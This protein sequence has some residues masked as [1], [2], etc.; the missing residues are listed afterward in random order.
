MAARSRLISDLADQVRRNATGETPAWAAKR[1]AAVPAELIAD[2]QI[3]RAAT[4]V[5]PGDL[6]PTGPSQIGQFFAALQVRYRQPN[7]E[8][9]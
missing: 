8:M 2:M 7:E 1:H 3:W 5:G 6:R 4:Q 9:R